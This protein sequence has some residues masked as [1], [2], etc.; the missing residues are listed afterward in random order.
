MSQLPCHL[1]IRGLIKTGL[2]SLDKQ[3]LDSTGC[4]NC[5]ECQTVFS[6]WDHPKSPPFIKGRYLIAFLLIKHL[7][8]IC[9]LLQVKDA[10]SEAT[11]SK[12]LSPSIQVFSG[13]MKLADV[14]YDQKLEDTKSK[15][16]ENLAVNLEAIVSLTPKEDDFSILFPFYCLH[17]LLHTI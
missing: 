6:M 10:D 17:C 2:W 1:H 7:T 12:Q 11:L 4:F 8:L 3:P 14:P 13:H 5:S 16:F 9:S 15:E